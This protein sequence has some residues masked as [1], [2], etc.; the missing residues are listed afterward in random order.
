VITASPQGT[1]S[2]VVPTGS[3]TSAP[4]TTAPAPTTPAPATA[5]PEALL[6]DLEETA[7]L[8]IL[9]GGAQVTQLDVTAGQTY[10]FRIT[11]TAGFEHNF[12]IGPAEALEA[13][14]TEGLVGVGSFTEGTREF[15]FRFSDP[16]V[17][18]QFACTVPGHY[19]LMHG[20]FVIG[21]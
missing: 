21:Q 14:Q 2:Q 19:Q 4:A 3:P 12:Y 8:R 13:N 7:D 9:Q 10:T 1:P 16:S 6:F 5:S 20:D 15:Q 17:Q 18:L 11:N